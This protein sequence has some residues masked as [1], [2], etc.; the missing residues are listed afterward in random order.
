[1]GDF[2]PA[3]DDGDAVK[4]KGLPFARGCAMLAPMAGVTDM[5]FRRICFEHG[6]AFAVTEMISAKGYLLSSGNPK[7]AAL[8]ATDPSEA[9]RIA[10]QLF[11]NEPEA[12]REALSS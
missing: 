5:A 12:I 6:C 3:A 10:A 11:G 9:G 8:L 7:Q 2:E 1:M 4:M